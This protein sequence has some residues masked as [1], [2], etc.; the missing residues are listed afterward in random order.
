MVK[1]KEDIHDFMKELIK[2]KPFKKA[3][4]NSFAYRIK[5]EN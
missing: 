2:E 1:S 5:L 3:S 4:H